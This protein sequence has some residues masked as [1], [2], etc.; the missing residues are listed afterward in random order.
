MPISHDEVKKA[1][2]KSQHCQRNWDLSKQM[3]KEDIDLFVSAVS[4][5]PSKQ[6][7]A[8]Y[9]THFITNREL[10]EKIHAKTDGFI[11]SFDEG[12]STTNPQV[13]ANL[14]VIFEAKPVDLRTDK[15]VNRNA[16]TY[17]FAKTDGKISSDTELCMERDR[18]MAVGIA[19]G[20][21]NLSATLMGYSTGCCACF[22]SEGI[23]ELLGLEGSPMLLMGIGFKDA[24]QNRRVHHVD[25]SFVFPTK[26]KQQI[27]ISHIS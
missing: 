11:I 8:Y 7:V 12:T 20:Y 19:A 14:L 27:E 22:D 5:C 26:A 4:Q 15:D 18:N 9:R 3:A 21:L 25:K 23:K 13:L 6:N 10:I 2:L 16:Q 24:D 17:E 1:I